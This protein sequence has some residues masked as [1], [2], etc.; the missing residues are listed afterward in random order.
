MLQ[1]VE[2]QFKNITGTL[3][4]ILFGTGEKSAT[5]NL[6]WTS[7]LKQTA[8]NYSHSVSKPRRL[9]NSTDISLHPYSTFV[10]CCSSCYSKWHACQGDRAS[11]SFLFDTLQFATSRY[12]NNTT[13]RL[14]FVHLWEMY[15]RLFRK[16]NRTF[17]CDMWGGLGNKIKFPSKERGNIKGRNI[18]RKDLCDRET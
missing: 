13:P 9:K 18:S 5:Q 2:R 17:E 6:Y 7:R 4:F 15:A 8:S 10:L 3:Q 1:P 11:V 14:H 12:V 16:G